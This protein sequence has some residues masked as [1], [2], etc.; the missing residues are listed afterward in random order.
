MA[1]T[2]NDNVNNATLTY[3]NRNQAALFNK[4]AT[5]TYAALSSFP[6]SQ[7]TI[8]NGTSGNLLVNAFLASDASRDYLI[9]TGSKDTIYGITNSNQVSAKVLAGTGTVYCQ[10][11]FYSH[12]I[13]P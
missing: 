4:V 2:A 11:Q 1:N 8:Y 9:P 7:V 3:T 10:V 13:A 6:G 12:N 5:V